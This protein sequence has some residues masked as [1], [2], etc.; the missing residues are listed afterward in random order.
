MKSSQIDKTF[1]TILII[2]SILGLFIF[3]SASLGLIVESWEGFQNVILKQLVLG[4]FLGW[5]G[6]IVTSKIKYKNWGKISEYLF[7][8][9]ILVSLLVFIPNLGMGAGGAKRWIDLGFL[10]FQPGEFLKLG[11]IIFYATFLAAIKDNIKDIRRG[12]IPSIVI[13]AIP[14][15]VLLKQPDLGT[16][17]SIVSSWMAMFLV[18]GGKKT[19]FL[20]IILLGIA[21]VASMAYVKP[22][23]MERIKTFLDPSR[24][25]LGAGYQVRQSLIA[26]GSG[27]ITGRGLGQ[28]IQKFS[29]LPEAIG[30]SIFA[31]AG[32]E[33]GFIGSVMI[34]LLFLFLA[35]RGFTVAGQT[36]DPFGRLLVV[37]FVTLIISQSFINMGAMLGILPLTG[38]P[39]IFLSHGGTALFFAL[40]EMGIVL[41]ISKAQ[42]R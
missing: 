23:A 18:A 11:F 32:E 5:L 14:A 6:L 17:L 24:D 15:A 22:Y 19:H 34:V 27:R 20:G 38:V 9:S 16:L 36:Q 41:N 28:S 7:I 42:T 8:F 4:L 31:V 37:G 35:L 3:T 25:P 13:V 10:S 1:L 39:L 40:I 26:I 29:F 2:L 21:M 12:L 33:F 30:D